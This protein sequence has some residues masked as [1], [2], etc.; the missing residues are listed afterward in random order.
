M[1]I[2]ECLDYWYRN[3]SDLN[4]NDEKHQ[5]M[6]AGVRLVLAEVEAILDGNFCHC[7]H[8]ATIQGMC[9]ECKYAVHEECECSKD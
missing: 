1:S 8:P 4:S 3:A 7:G 5:W 2:R 9:T 6:A